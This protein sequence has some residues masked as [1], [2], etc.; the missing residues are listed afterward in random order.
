MTAYTSSDNLGVIHGHYRYPYGGGMAS[1]AH[2]A[3]T[4]MAS[5]LASRCGTVV[6]T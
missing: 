3:T 6:T 5:G 1:L 2:I 4:N